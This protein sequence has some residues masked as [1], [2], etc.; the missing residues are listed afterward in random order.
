MKCFHRHQ[1]ISFLFWQSKKSSSNTS[2]V[3]CSLIV[4]N[5]N[6]KQYEQKKNFKESV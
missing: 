1:N 4:I 2:K 6:D 3:A 5:T